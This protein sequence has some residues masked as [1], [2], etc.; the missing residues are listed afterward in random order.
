VLRNP[1]ATD[2]GET[3]PLWRVDTIRLQLGPCPSPQ[4]LFRAHGDALGRSG[5][6]ARTLEIL[7][8]INGYVLNVDCDRDD[9]ATDVIGAVG[10]LREC[11][12]RALAGGS[13]QYKTCSIVR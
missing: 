6:V 4:E 2:T 8:G 1:D 12:D 5:L 11:D 9:G 13:W 7:A 3:R 10:R